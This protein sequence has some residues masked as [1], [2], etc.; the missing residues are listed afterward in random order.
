MSNFSPMHAA[1]PYQQM[2]HGYQFQQQFNQ[3]MLQMSADGRVAAP[4]SFIIIKL[5]V[6]LYWLSVA[7]I[8]LDSYFNSN[9]FV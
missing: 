1:L 8:R 2:P 9:G 7:H 6:I 3:H 4:V 5:K